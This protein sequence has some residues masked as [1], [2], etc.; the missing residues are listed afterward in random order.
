MPKGKV[1]DGDRKKRERMKSKNPR[2][3]KRGGLKAKQPGKQKMI[4]KFPNF[5]YISKGEM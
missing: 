3:E 5:D 1:S 4:E 2:G